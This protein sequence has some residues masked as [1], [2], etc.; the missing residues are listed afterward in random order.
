[1]KKSDYGKNIL[2]ILLA[3]ITTVFAWHDFLISGNNVIFVFIFIS[4]IFIIRH[5]IDITNKRMTIVTA[6]L[7]IVFAIIE[8]ICKS[9]NYD[10]T[11]NHIFNK[12]IL[13]NLIGYFT[14]AW[15]LITNLFYLFE[16]ANSDNEKVKKILDS[17]IM[18]F[19][20]C[21]LLMLIVWS[22]IFLR[23]YPGIATPDSSS[24]I[25]QTVGIDKVTDHHP[26]AHTA[27]ISVFINIG[28]KL[29]NSVETGIALY[30]IF[31][32]CFLA[33][34]FSLVLNYL[35]QIKVPS[36][37]RLV[38]LLWYM[39]YPINAIYSITMWKDIIFA[40]IVPLLIIQYIRLIFDTEN[41]LKNKLNIFLCILIS[42]FTII[43]RHNGLYMILLSCP[44]VIIVLRKYWKKVVP[45]FLAIFIINSVYNFTIYNILKIPK[46]SVVEMLSI[47]L[48][49]IARVEKYHRDELNDETMEKINKLFIKENIGDY[50]NPTLSDDV[51]W[52]VDEDYLGNNKKEFISLWLQLLRPYFK[53][54]VESFISNSY[55]YYYP[56]AKNWVYSEAT[57]GEKLGIEQH[58]IIKSDKISEYIGKTS[59]RDNPVTSMLFS[60]GFIFWVIIACLG[61]K[62]YKKEYK[63]ILVYLPIGIL[64]LTLIASPVFC[65]YRYA[66]PL[67]TTLPLL[68][69]LNFIKKEGTKLNG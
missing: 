62:I 10:Y 23:Y 65:E 46:G 16:K 19:L 51:K 57:M 68:I 28:T 8:L 50:Y 6:V 54:Y 64:W 30:S 38:I 56:E 13:V 69:S 12:W 55:G 2:T 20:V 32:M 41:F 29:F 34:G 37:V 53:D 33:T 61:Y 26:F 4:A 63:Y 59:S 1:M 35:K 67:F 14:I 7:S 11:L 44:F 25:Y 24:Q 9:I 39:F 60:V 43:I 3:G 66:Y 45:L 5:T 42:V 40:G 58:P 15:C 47:P 18:H 17:K 27:I 21:A 22:P 49:Q 36:I 52:S 48:Q 31:S